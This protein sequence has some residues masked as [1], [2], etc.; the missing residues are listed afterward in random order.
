MRRLLPGSSSA[1]TFGGWYAAQ[2]HFLIPR[3]KRPKSF[4]HP[5]VDSAQQRQIGRPQTLPCKER[6]A[7]YWAARERERE[8][9]SSFSSIHS[10]DCCKLFNNWTA[11][12][13]KQKERYPSNNCTDDRRFCSSFSP[14]KCARL[15]PS[16]P[17]KSL[18]S[19][20]PVWLSE[21]NVFRAQKRVGGCVQSFSGPKF[22]YRWLRVYK[23]F[24]EA[25]S[26]SWK[27]PMRSQRGFARRRSC[28]SLSIHFAAAKSHT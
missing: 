2:S 8:K 1:A 13:S 5:C 20:K 16:P 12:A 27:Q 14:N 21:T 25:F 3:W 10:Q 7:A 18:F 4:A 24:S 11:A 15:F 22:V 28:R 17:E 19:L 23:H 6:I 9:A 26:F